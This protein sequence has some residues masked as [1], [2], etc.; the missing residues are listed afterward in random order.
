MKAIDYVKAAADE[1][2]YDD[3]ERGLVN[4]LTDQKELARFDYQTLRHWTEFSVVVKVKDAHVAF[5][6]ASA[7]GDLSIWDKGYEW[8]PDSMYYVEPVEVTT[9]EWRYVKAPKD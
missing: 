1:A 2:G 6:Y 4:F 5:P 8:Y 9:T 7:D 3:T